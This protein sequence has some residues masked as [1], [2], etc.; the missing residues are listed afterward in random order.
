MGV[1]DRLAG[2]RAAVDADV[3]TD[4]GGD[5]GLEFFAQEKNQRLGFE[6]GWKIGVPNDLLFYFIQEESNGFF[7]NS[8]VV[9]DRLPDDFEIDP[10]I[11]VYEFV[12]HGCDLNPGEIRLS[13]AN[14]RRDLLDC[15]PDD[16]QTADNGI[17]GLAVG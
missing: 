15:L 1:K 14:L 11:L 12:P 8:E 13:A 9:F 17:D 7:E 2:A 10:E 6:G 16:L 3:E 4:D 5:F